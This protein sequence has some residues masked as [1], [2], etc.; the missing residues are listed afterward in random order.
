M[1]AP[2]IR[3]YIGT[4]PDKVQPQIAFDTNIDSYLDWQTLQFAPDLVAFGAWADQVRA[5]LIV[6]NLP[7]LTGRELDAVRVNA[8]GNGVEFADVTSF[9][10]ALLDDTS[11][12]D[13]RATLGLGTAATQTANIAALAVADPNHLARA[14]QVVTYVTGEIATKYGTLANTTSGTAFDFTGIPAGVS[15]ITLT[16]RNVRLSGADDLLIQIGPAAGIVTTGYASSGG[17]L[18]TAAGLSTSTS[19]FVTR[20]TSTDQEVSG[21]LTLKRESVGS[22]SWISAHSMSTVGT[23]RTALVGGG[24]VALAGQLTQL[25]LTRVGSSTFDLGSAN[26]SWRF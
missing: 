20:R 17:A 8:A 23:A 2:V 22:N 14:G 6:G 1:T 21:V 3:Q 7:P 11:F 24:N 4:I 26:I 19:G 16:L 13:M 10:W 5:A 12:S 25:R 18:N 9:G 15:E